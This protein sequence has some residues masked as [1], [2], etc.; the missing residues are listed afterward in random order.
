MSEERKY[1]VPGR[2]NFIGEHTDYNLGFVFPGA[3]DLGLDFSAKIRGGEEHLF[4]SGHFRQEERCALDGSGLKYDWS[5]FFRQVLSLLSEKGYLIQA[6]ECK[7]DGNLPVGAGMSSSSAITCGLIYILNDLCSLGMSNIEMVNLASEAERG[8]GLDGGKMDQYAILM[9]KKDTLLLLDCKTLQ[10]EE[11]NIELG[12]YELVLIDTKVSHSLL[13]S[14]YNDRHGECK[15]GLEVIQESHS[16]INTVRDITTSV[17]ENPRDQLD[18]THY[19]RLSFV[20]A[21]NERVLLSKT[22]FLNHDLETLGALLYASHD[23]LSKKYEVSCTELDFIVD[24]TRSKDAFLGARMMGGGF[25]GCVIALVKSDMIDDHFKVLSSA[26]E[27]ELG[28]K[29]AI[30][31]VKISQGI[32]RVTEDE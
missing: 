32:R 7:F 29:P 10:H 30:Y 3:V 6:I 12:Q 17:L 16:H 19:K 23:G 28:R 4:Y 14:E 21:E 8:S 25:G 5:V 1:R 18:V 20:L 11:V 9:G 27:I 24:W 26:Y 13:D 31:P 2:I 22:A 15:A